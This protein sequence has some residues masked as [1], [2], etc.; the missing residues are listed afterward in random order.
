MDYRSTMSFV[1]ILWFCFNRTYD[2]LWTCFKIGFPKWWSKMHDG[3]H[4]KVVLVCVEIIWR[5]NY[6]LPFHSWR[7]IEFMNRKCAIWIYAILVFLAKFRTTLFL[8]DRC[9][10]PRIKNL[11]LISAKKFYFIILNVFE[12]K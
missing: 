6:L 12:R 7:S 2:L 4:L 5:R 8:V 11:L 1:V 3:I 9:N 10:A